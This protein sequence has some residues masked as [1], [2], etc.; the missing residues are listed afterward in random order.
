MR[1]NWPHSAF[2]NF[3][4]TRSLRA[5]NGVL[6]LCGPLSRHRHIGG[7]K[8]AARIDRLLGRNH[9]LDGN[10]SQGND[11]PKRQVSCQGG[12]PTR[13]QRPLATQGVQERT[14][15]EQHYDQLYSQRAVQCHGKMMACEGPMT[16]K[17]RPFPS[18]SCR[19][20]T[21]SIR[22]RVCR[23]LG[24]DFLAVCPNLKSPSPRK[25]TSSIASTP[26]RG[27]RAPRETLPKQTK[28]QKS[29]LT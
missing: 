6:A 8:V 23:G 14:A 11:R 10:Q 20:R 9:K 27:P 7:S 25:G 2:T 26:L 1:T 21:S 3:T 5:L 16:S 15:T 24:T 17:G 12:Q 18:L 28:F 19:E 29:C 13:E 4:F 22:A